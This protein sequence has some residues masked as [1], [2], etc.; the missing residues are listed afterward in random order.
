MAQF[1][2]SDY[3]QVVRSQ[4]Q[5]I[6]GASELAML[7]APTPDELVELRRGVA[8]MTSA[9]KENAETLSDEQIVKIAEDAQIDPANFAIF[10]NGYAIHKKRPG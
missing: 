8:I 10:I 4:F 3:G 7:A 9:E 5:D 1:S 2:D 6:R